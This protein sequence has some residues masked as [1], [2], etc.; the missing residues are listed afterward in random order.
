MINPIIE[1]SATQMGPELGATIIIK[2]TI[3]LAAAALATLILRRA[4]ASVRY[5]VW[6]VAIV[7]LIMLPLLSMVLP[8][9]W[10][11]EVVPNTEPPPPSVSSLVSQETRPGPAGIPGRADDAGRPAAVVG[12]APGIP[13]SSVTPVLEVLLI[14]W[15]AGSAV[16]LGRLALHL[17]R[18]D[19]ITRHGWAATD[20][21]IQSASRSALLATGAKRAVRVIM[22]DRSSLPFSWG[23][24]NPTVVLPEG[25]AEWPAEQKESVLLHEIA[26][27]VRW[28]YPIHLAVEIAKALYWPNPLVWFASRRCAMERERACDDYALRGGAPSDR[29]ASHLIEIARV[30]IERAPLSAT[31]MAG[32]PGIFERIRHVMNETLDRSPIRLARLTLVVAVA[33]ALTLPL[34]TMKVLRAEDWHVPTTAD[35]VRDLREQ[36]D[37]Q[38][39]RRAAWWLG[40][41]EDTTAVPAVI[42]ALRD[43]DG[44]VRLVAAW[45]LGEIKDHK[46]IPPLIRRLERDEDFFV[47]EMAALALGEIGQSEAVAPLMEAFKTEE[48]LRPAIIWALGE[49]RGDEAQVARAIAF[50]KVGE[51]PWENSEVWARAEDE[52]FDDVSFEIDVLLVQT[53]SNDPQERYRATVL[54]GVLGRVDGIDEV[55]IVVDALLEALRDPVPKVRA[56]AVWSLDETNPS[57]SMR[58]G[59]EHSETSLTEHRMNSLGYVFLHSHRYEQAIEIFKANV[60]LYPKSGNVYDSLGEAY[61]MTGDVERAIENY[62]KSVEIDPENEHGK[63]ML[64]ILYKFR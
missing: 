31:T 56:A 59:Y 16:M 11:G 58:N 25:A 51:K 20:P 57:R 12:S 19:S 8:T 61:V 10:P 48:D 38:V 23:L 40:E 37:P 60:K 49:I 63:E 62:E 4:S 21:E 6:S 43:E 28:D 30:Q 5:A 33:F 1:Q 22:T 36:E 17:M 13:M 24:W 55:E 7:T 27:I 42:S 34:A 47:R 3:V 52:N 14:V 64:E 50:G 39:R 46:A 54:L 44:D 2:A 32:E 18:V 29:Y 53:R 35:L 45:A 15:L 9:S 26:H 41:H